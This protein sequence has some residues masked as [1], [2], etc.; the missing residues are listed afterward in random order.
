[1]Q[2]QR[3]P[4]REHHVAADHTGGAEAMAHCRDLV[5]PAQPVLRFDRR[6]L[7][8]TSEGVNR[9]RLVEAVG[10]EPQVRQFECGRRAATAGGQDH[11]R[12]H[13][14]ACVGDVVGGRDP[15]HARLVDGHGLT[16]VVERSGQFEH[17][18]DGELGPGGRHRGDLG[19]D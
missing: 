18:L 10:R 4:E 17:E 16:R 11:V 8:L 5:E 1:L 7:G 9:G 13:R 14:D 3:E 2:D 15:L 12:Q 6:T 19:A